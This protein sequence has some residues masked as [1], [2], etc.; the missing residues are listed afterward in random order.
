MMKLDAMHMLRL[1]YISFMLD[2]IFHSWIG[3]VF[4]IF[5]YMKAQV[6]ASLILTNQNYIFSLQGTLANLSKGASY[7]VRVYP[8]LFSLE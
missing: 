2:L 6:V 4:E 5:S 1:T 3:D 7:V 8:T